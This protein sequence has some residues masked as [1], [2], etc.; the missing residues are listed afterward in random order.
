MGKKIGKIML[1]HCYWVTCLVFLIICAIIAAGAGSIVDGKC[2][3]PSN[4]LLQKLRLTSIS[5]TVLYCSD[6]C[7]C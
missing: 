4:Y 3:D 6:S 5:A 2:E 1:L 7:P